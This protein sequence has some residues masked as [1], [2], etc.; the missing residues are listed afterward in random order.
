LL[1]GLLPKPKSFFACP[2]TFFDKSKACSRRYENS[3]FGL[4]Q[5]ISLI[6]RFAKIYEQKKRFNELLKRSLVWATARKDALTMGLARRIM[7]PSQILGREDTDRL[8]PLHNSFER[9]S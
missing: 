6:F 7:A 9:L 5:L 2:E 3:P 8:R 1:S 4:K